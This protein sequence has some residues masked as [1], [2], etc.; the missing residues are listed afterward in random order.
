MA[1]SAYEYKTAWG[2]SP[3][4]SCVPSPSTWVSSPAAACG[5]DCWGSG[6]TVVGTEPNFRCKSNATGTEY[7]LQSRVASSCPAYGTV[8]SSGKFDYGTNPSGLNP[9]ACTPGGC[10]VVFGGDAPVGRSMVGGVYHYWA[11]GSYNHMDSGSSC[12]PGPTN[13][14]MS[15]S[16]SIPPSTCLPTDI[17][18]TINGQLKCVVKTT[19][20][21]SA[22]S[23]SEA[24]Q[25]VLV[26]DLNNADGSVTRETTT[27]FADGSISV[28]SEVFPSPTA[29]SPTSASTS[30]KGGSGTQAAAANPGA[31]PG[32]GSSTGGGGSVNVQFPSDYARAGEAQTAASSITDALGPKID[33]ITETGADPVDPLQPQGSE[34]DQAFFQGTFNSLLGWQLPAHSSQCPTSSFSFRSTSYTIDSHCQLVSN[35]FS[36]LSA[37]MSAVWT[38]LALFILLGA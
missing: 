10:M 24:K 9:I 29:S 20:A 35:H 37:V 26:T 19:G 17:A 18:M 30:I 3:V 27:T 15:A 11:Q 16:A 6:F 7:G 8:Y 34:F 4:D 28:K 33:K 14:P 31:V 23:P 13:A 2:H 1:W 32:G 25:T 5:Q 21:A 38:V 12:T 22:N 36:A